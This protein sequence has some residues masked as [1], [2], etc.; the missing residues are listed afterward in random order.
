MIVK[1][2]STIHP[3]VPPL[4]LL[5]ALSTVFLFAN[6]RSHFYRGAQHDHLSSQ[7][8]VLA[9]NLSPKHHFLMFFRQYPSI[10]N[11]HIYEP[12]NRFP[13]GTYALIK[14]SILPFQGIA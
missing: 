11:T 9:A 10:N 7:S 14:L 12:Y 8:M 6:D 4:L 1:F 13:I 2:K 5:F 3:A